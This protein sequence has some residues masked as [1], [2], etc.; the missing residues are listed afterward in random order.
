MNGKGDRNRSLSQSYRDGW[1]RIFG[2]LSDL[3]PDRYCFTCHRYIP[4]GELIVLDEDG[5]RGPIRCP[6]C[7][8]TVDLYCKVGA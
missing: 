3:F 8:S 4:C 1:D 6:H 7:L 2:D 5:P